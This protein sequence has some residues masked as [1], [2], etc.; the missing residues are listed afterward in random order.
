MT[1]SNCAHCGQVFLFSYNNRCKDCIQVH[2]NDTRRVKDYVLK[3][4]KATLLEVYHQTGVSVKTLIELN[5]S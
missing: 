1:L 5:G 3:N 2:I 4:P